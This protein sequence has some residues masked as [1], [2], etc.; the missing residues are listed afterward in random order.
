MNIKLKTL[1]SF[2]MITALVFGFIHV[3]FPADN[4][5]FER[6]HIFL[7]NLCTGGSI[8]LY[9]TQGRK[10]VSKTIKFF[11]LGSLIY[12]FSAFFKIYPITILVSVPLFILVEK[13]RIKRFSLFPVIFF[14]FK[15]PVSE[16]FHQAS[17]LCLSIGIVM[18]GMVILNNEYFKFVTM[19]KLTLN[20][21]FLGFSF[22]L[23]LITLS[24]V[25]AMLKKIETS[26]I[27]LLMEI[28]FWTITL[29]VIIFFIFILLEKFIPQIFVTLAL[30]TA[31]VLVF[32][33][34]SKFADRTQQKFFLTSGIGFLIFTAI[35]GIAYIFMQMSEGYD[36]QKIKWL[37]HIHVFASLYGWNLCGLS[38][39]C[40]FGDFPIKL[41]STS[42]IFMHWLTAIVLAPLGI[43]YGWFAIFAII[44]Y[45]FI[46]L[47]L[48]FSS[49]KDS[50]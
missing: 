24:L 6:L 18:A 16:K 17:L 2:L 5:S 34:Y 29:G 31:V 42:V 14:K 32:Y 11:F 1:F 9:Y 21:F 22:P 13:I 20:T 4:Y 46:V 10:K 12:A 47:T 25:F 35:T 7:F 15:E 23:S 44:G 33:L 45:S 38:I 8:L 36:P 27:K 41:H 3:Y 39:I 28:C 49:N 30:F 50:R 37:L 19:E 48:F 43:F 40:R 26:S